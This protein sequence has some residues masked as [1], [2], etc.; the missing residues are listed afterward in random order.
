M[1]NRPRKKQPKP[2]MHWIMIGVWSCLLI[3]SVVMLGRYIMDAVRVRQTNAQLAETYHAAAATQAPAQV[4]TEQ[5]VTITATPQPVVEMQAQAVQAATTA[6]P[7]AR[8]TATYDPFGGYPNNRYREVSQQFKQLQKT[9][10]DICAWLTIG[11]ALDQAVVLRDNVFYLNHDYLGNSNV[12]GALFLDE[13]MNL[14]ERPKAYLVYGHN[15][16]TQEMFGV[17]H[18]YEDANFLRSNAIITFNTMY[19]DGAFAV[20]AAGTVPMDSGHLTYVPFSTL[21]KA[22]DTLRQTVIEGFMLASDYKIALDV[23]ADDQLLVLITCTGDDSERRFVA[24]RRLRDGE[25]DDT[26]RMTYL[27]MERR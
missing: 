17:L 5:P 26:L 3:W 11:D 1:R 19:E 12:N 9:S 24:A 22:G 13:R 25:S 2:I 20:F 14:L 10:K 18:K 16:K 8:P 15:M 27:M 7:T 4:A 21:P 6:V 23:T